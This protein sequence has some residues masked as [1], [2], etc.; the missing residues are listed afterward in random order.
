MN[1]ITYDDLLRRQDDAIRNAY[2]NPQQ[3]VIR[4]VNGI[5]PGLVPSARVQAE[6]RE[7]ARVRAQKRDRQRE[8][9]IGYAK[10]FAASRYAEAAR[11]IANNEDEQAR[12]YNGPSAHA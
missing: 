6:R 5:G 8:Q 2:T 11:D 7:Q 10:G 3:R 4:P 12:A 9:A 1:V